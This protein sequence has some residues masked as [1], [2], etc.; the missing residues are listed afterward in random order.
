MKSQSEINKNLAIRYFNDVFN[1]Q[2]FDVITELLSPL[3]TFNG[4]PSSVEANKA[5]VISLHQTYP[6]LHFSVESILAE[7]DMVALRWKMEAP[8]SGARPEGWITGTNII[9]FVEGQALTND[10]NG[11][12]SPSWTP[13][14]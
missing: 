14:S 12:T 13:A 10:Q 2:K 8:A 1:E 4:A 5:W 11:Q 6:G 9:T 3:Y 7:D